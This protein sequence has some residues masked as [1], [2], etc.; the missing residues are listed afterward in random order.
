[1]TNKIE[2][3]NLIVNNIYVE[4]IK[5]NDGIKFINKK[6]S[7][8][9]YFNGETI[10]PYEWAPDY[11]NTFSMYEVSAYT[12]Q[13]SGWI[14]IDRTSS[15]SA[16]IFINDYIANTF[17]NTG[18]LQLFVSKG[19]IISASSDFD[20]TFSPCISDS[21]IS[22]DFNTTPYDIWSAVPIKT[23]D[24]M[25]Q[26]KNFYIPN[27]SVWNIKIREANNLNITSISDNK[28]FDGDKF[29]CNIQFEKI[30]IAENLFSQC[31][32]LTSF[33]GDLSLLKNA[34]GMFFNCNLDAQSVEN[35]LS[36]LSTYDSGEH[37]IT[38][39]IQESA[40][41]S[42]Q[43]ITGSSLEMGQFYNIS[44][45]G[46]NID[47]FLRDNRYFQTPYDIYKDTIHLEENGSLS[48]KSYYIPDASKWNSEIYHQYNLNITAV[49]NNMAYNESN[50]VCNIQS[51]YI[52]NGTKLFHNCYNLSSF[53]DPLTSLVDG[54]SMF[55]NCEKLTDF[56][57]DLSS[58][59]DGTNMF[60]GCML[61][62]A[63]IEKILTTIPT[64]T[65][66]SHKLGL[67]LLTIEEAN[68]FNEI[69]GASVEIGN[70][71]NIEYKGWTITTY[72]AKDDREIPTKYDIWKN[73]ISLNKETTEIEIVDLY[74]P[75]ASKW[76]SEIYNNFKLRITKVEENKAYNGS[77]FVC[78]IQSQEIVNG[79]NL[80]NDVATLTT[81]VDNLSSL[82]S[83]VNMF[84]GCSL[85]VISVENI[86]TSIPTYTSGEHIL[87]MRI[88]VDAVE[89]FI[90]LTGINEIGEEISSVS[91]KGWTIQVGKITR[92][93]S[94]YD[95]WEGTSYIP[96]ASSWR[97]N[98]YDEHGLIITDIRDNKI[99]NGDE[100]VCNIQCESIENIETMDSELSFIVGEAFS[101][102]NL[103]N[104][105]GDFSSL[106]MMLST[107]ANTNISNFSGNLSSVMMGLFPFS[108]CYKLSSIDSDIS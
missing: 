54:N 90:E 103:T 81:F 6:E 31:Q 37:N 9:R 69:T 94:D 42:F 65:T 107:F 35:I 41:E 68:K 27:A 47:V 39:T 106:I 59:S 79:D 62:S 49:E 83:G 13:A 78:N 89:K 38:L 44:F 108:G 45:K 73:V 99:Y 64:Y 67:T 96:D 100:F 43:Q 77:D 102:T 20:F 2:S 87:T 5:N 82:S 105:S 58:L 18:S 53:K 4:S 10:L 71:Y 30:E 75:D 72:I 98:V 56:E 23:D 57:C 92:I 93:I 36:S 48:L 51:Q 66:G 24:G 46:W 40:K 91:F 16:S 33:N 11:E 3:S 21:K 22:F 29:V 86:L 15:D 34:P 80:F 17:S 63:S 74:L 50:F 8:N 55:L 26:L 7:V 32:N 25:I 14:S 60:I 101:N 28:A 95:I 52:E 61:N 19:D 84:N 88:K 76:N 12:A 104:V 70:I 1:M 97:T 85:D